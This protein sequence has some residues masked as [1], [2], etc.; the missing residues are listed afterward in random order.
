MNCHQFFVEQRHD[1]IIRKITRVRIDRKNGFIEKFPKKSSQIINIFE[2][3][4]KSTADPRDKRFVRHFEEC[5]NTKW[6]R[7]RKKKKEKKREKRGKNNIRFENYETYL[8]KRNA[9]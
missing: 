3:T 2:R 8:R 7:N 9:T 1:R 6:K 4:G 5:R